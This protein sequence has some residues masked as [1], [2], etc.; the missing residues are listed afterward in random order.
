M[1]M[2]GE[3][4]FVGHAGEPNGRPRIE[5]GLLL[6]TSFSQSVNH[7]VGIENGRGRYLVGSTEVN[8]EAL[9]KAYES[10]NHRRDDSICSVCNGKANGIHFG[11]ISCAACNAFFRRSTAESRRFICGKHGDCVVQSTVR[12]GCR[13]C[14][15]KACLIAGMKPDAVQPHRDA[16]GKKPKAERQSK[17]PNF[18]AQPP[19]LSRIRLKQEERLT[20]DSKSDVQVEQMVVD[21][22]LFSGRSSECTLRSGPSS[23]EQP[24][25]ECSTRTSVIQRLEHVEITSN[26][27]SSPSNSYTPSWPPVEEEGLIEQGLR[28]YARLIERRRL[29]YG[30]R[31]IEKLMDGS[32]PEY[33]CWQ[34][35]DHYRMQDNLAVPTAN[36]IEFIRSFRGFVA[37]DVH[38]QIVLFRHFGAAFIIFE[39]YY[40]SYQMSNRNDGRTNDC[41]LQKG[42]LHTN[43]IYRQDYTFV[44]LDS[45]DPADEAAA[46]QTRGYF[47]PPEAK[48]AD[49]QLVDDA[50]LVRLTTPYI[51]YAMETLIRPM[52]S[53]QMNDVE[54]IG[55]SLAILF[56]P[57]LPNLSPNGRLQVKQLRNQLFVDWFSYYETLGDSIEDAAIRMGNT[58]LMFPVIEEF[59][60]HYQEHFHLLRVFGVIDF[61]PV[62]D[63]FFA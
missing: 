58:L 2:L 22:E 34:G 14:R 28:S 23:N 47:V 10:S 13:A 52:D 24:I 44:Q 53:L 49:G 11:A 43:R 41:C 29:V 57:N 33:R 35:L 39:K 6:D 16:I 17:S 20:P 61:D 1:L 32:E 60:R 27:M 15:L 26:S 36:L 21:G 45:E 59:V 9:R 42:G 31:S 63:E 46:M 50:T 51:R 8:I 7:V 3:Q 19:D 12:T 4:L 38:D 48:K 37:L 25:I 5:E 18:A 62:L 40:L 30:A 55:S 56:E 54:F